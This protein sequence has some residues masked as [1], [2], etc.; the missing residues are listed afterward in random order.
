[1]KSFLL[2]L[3]AFTTLFASAQ[4]TT[5]SWT[6][7]G[8]TREYISYVPASYD[9]TT[10][11]PVVFC[12]HG[13]G[14]NMTNFYGI[15][16]NFV[17]DTANFIVITP[18]A[19]VDPL[20]NSTAWNSGA[21]YL[22]Y[23]LNPSVDDIGFFGAILDT[24]IDN[25]SIN[26]SK[27]YSCGFSMGGF[28]TNRLGCEM[29]DRIAA[30]ASVAGTIGSGLTCNPGRAVPACHFHGTLDSTVYYTGN[31]YGNDAE[32]LALFW[33]GNNNCSTTPTVTTLPDVAMDNLIITHKLFPACDNGAEVELYRVDSCEHVWLTPANDI[34]YTTEIWNFF[35]K[36]THS[37]NVGIAITNPIEFSVY[38]NPSAGQFTIELENFDN[39]TIKVY[40]ILG[41]LVYSETATALNN[42]M[43]VSFLSNGSYIVEVNQSNYSKT[44]S[45]IISK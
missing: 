32:D 45:V 31:L 29:N 6:F 9:G 15:G 35:T 14:D 34:F 36:H 19:L 25:Y 24:L 18:Q 41:S 21:S 23:V 30:I 33:A 42:V 5:H 40:D 39:T 12:L 16:M 27:V 3:F 11:V 38:P 28:M 37:E 43:D 26:Q 13:L 10:P 17:A 1:M 2:S 4:Q 20:L 7:D 44:Q 22:G 8:E